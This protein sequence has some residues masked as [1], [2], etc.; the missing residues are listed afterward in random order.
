[1]GPRASLDDLET[2]KS[3]APEGIRTPNGPA[4]SLV[5][6]KHGRSVKQQYA[7]KIRTCAVT[8]LLFHTILKHFSADNGCLKE[9]M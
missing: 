8:I 3:L 6:D 4:N 2:R 7:D 1:V 9:H 5:T